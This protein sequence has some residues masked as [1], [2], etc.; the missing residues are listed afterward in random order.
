MA[1]MN[2]ISTTTTE[3]RSPSPDANTEEVRVLSMSEYKGAA[4][5]LAEAFAVDD[6]ARYFVDMPDMAS[7]SEERKWKLHVDILRYVVS[8]HCLDGIVTTIGPDY[9][10]VALW[11]FPSNISS[12]SQPGLTFSGCLPARM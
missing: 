7:Y 10:A 2:K 12:P 8:A 9:D 6:V 5:C 11:Y 4:Q 3:K 1:E